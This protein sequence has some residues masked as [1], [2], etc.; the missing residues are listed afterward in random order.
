MLIWFLQQTD[1]YS[2]NELVFVMEVLYV[3]CELL[4]GFQNALLH[5]ILLQNAEL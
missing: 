2:S 3:F 4:N 5:A 1:I